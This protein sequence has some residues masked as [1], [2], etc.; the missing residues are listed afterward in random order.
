MRGEYNAEDDVTLVTT[1]EQ[2]DR[3]DEQSVK[4]ARQLLK[5]ESTKKR[6][7]MVL[8]LYLLVDCKW[9]RFGGALFPN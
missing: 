4:V 5:R 7:G 2:D 6:A 3:E 8:T 1:C 9:Y